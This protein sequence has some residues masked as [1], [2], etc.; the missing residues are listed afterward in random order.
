MSDSMTAEVI[1]RRRGIQNAVQKGEM[2]PSQAERK[3]QQD[4]LPP[5][6]SDQ[7]GLRDVTTNST[8]WLPIAV[9]FYAWQDLGATKR[10]YERY[11]VWGAALWRDAQPGD[12]I[13]PLSEAEDRL[14]ADLVGG[15]VRGFGTD[16]DHVLTPVPREEWRLLDFKRQM[17]LAQ[18]PDG[19]VAYSGA[20]VLRHEVV[21]L[22]LSETPVVTVPPQSLLRERS[23]QPPPKRGGRPPIYD[24]DA[25][26]IE[27][28]K[29]AT[30]DKINDRPAL[31]RH[32]LAWFAERGSPEPGE[33]IFKDKMSKLF[34]T[35]GWE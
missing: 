18:L 4:G 24:W 34:R 16:R 31:S 32:L 10:E 5:F 12:M 15:L 6:I 8:W 29:L 1:A 33:S 35:L 19:N 22:W 7:D 30:E 21:P 11:R 25:M 9:L 26:W 23:D 2:T 13:M 14:R 20:F 3:A 28:V 17:N 27:V